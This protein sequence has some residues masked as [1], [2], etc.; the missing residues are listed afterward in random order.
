MRPLSGAVDTKLGR[1]EDCGP[2]ELQLSGFPI[3]T[4]SLTELGLDTKNPMDARV[5][6]P[7]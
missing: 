5:M 7:S 2:Y 3:C 4:N 6:A 1:T